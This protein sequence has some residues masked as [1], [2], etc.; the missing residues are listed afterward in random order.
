MGMFFD[1]VR[2]SNFACAVLAKTEPLAPFSVSKTK[3]EMPTVAVQTQTNDIAVQTEDVD[4]QEAE[5]RWSMTTSLPPN[6]VSPTN[7]V[8]FSAYS[9][10]NWWPQQPL[11]R[12]QRTE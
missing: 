7:D 11:K 4:L 9:S 10:R 1:Q 2:R 5:R 8:V 12:Q 6:I 3:T